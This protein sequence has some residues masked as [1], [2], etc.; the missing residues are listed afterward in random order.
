M[1]QVGTQIQRLTHAKPE[2]LPDFGK[3][4]VDISYG[5]EG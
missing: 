3:W 2:G 4:F 1:A 5:A